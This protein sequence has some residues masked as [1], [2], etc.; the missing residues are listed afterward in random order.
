[1]REGTGANRDTHERNAMRT[2]FGCSFAALLLLAATAAAQYPPY[3]NGFGG[4]P[5]APNGGYGGGQQYGGVPY[6]GS[7]LSP[8]LN[9][10]GGI[11]GT[12]NPAVNYYNFVR[13]NLPNVNRMGG[14]NPG[15]TGW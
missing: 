1:M 3:Q 4:Y 14:F 10:R 15:A 13:P 12:S 11:N 7:P 2:I 5:G 9:L 6:G 8:F